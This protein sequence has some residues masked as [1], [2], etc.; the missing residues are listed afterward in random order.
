MVGGFHTIA[1]TG[2]ECSGKTSVAQELGKE[3]VERGYKTI[4]VPLMA[5]LM[6]DNGFMTDSET[7]G[8]VAIESE[9]NRIKCIKSDAE[10]LN[11]PTVVVFD[12]GIADLKIE[13]G[14]DVYNATLAANDMTESDA[15]DIYDSVVFLDT[16]ASTSAH[17]RFYDYDKFNA[18]RSMLM[19]AKDNC[20]KLLE[21]WSGC[22]KF[23]KISNEDSFDAKVR[24]AIAAANHTAGLPTVIGK[25]DKF[26]VANLSSTELDKL[27]GVDNVSQGEIEIYYIEQDGVQTMYR[28]LVLDDG[29]EQYSASIKRDSATGPI[30]AR[31][32]HV[33]SKDE[34]YANMPQ[35]FRSVKKR[36]WS[37]GIDGTYYNLD[38]FVQPYGTTV[39]EVVHT[40][41]E[42]EG[43]PVSFPDFLMVLKNLKKDRSFTNLRVFQKLNPQFYVDV[44]DWN[45]SSN[46]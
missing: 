35:N 46:R 41:K 28:K 15:F 27:K 10:K 1:V 16:P 30:K 19:D 33:A 17:N 29:T 36:R 32:S 4:I 5:H 37:F 34:F 12:G 14:N 18:H 21:A 2:G 23:V 7:F 44:N 39:L 40:D 20:V 13:L 42:P 43:K 45:A 26:R 3:L 9:L 31:S 8:A 6:R 22:D 38:Q 25:P 24:N 11:I